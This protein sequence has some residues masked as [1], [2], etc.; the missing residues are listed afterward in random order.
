MSEI[1]FNTCSETNRTFATGDAARASELRF[2]EIQADCEGGQVPE[3]RPGDVI[4][5]ET[6]RYLG[7]GRDDFHGGLIEVTE[8]RSGGTP[9]VVVAK[10]QK[11]AYNWN[12]LA[13]WQ[14]RLRS[15]FGQTWAHPDPDSRPEFNKDWH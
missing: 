12:L 1:Q 11:S 10:E 13:T 5:V 3:L 7:H 8:F 2:R 14:Q 6:E 4:Y 9:F 15:K